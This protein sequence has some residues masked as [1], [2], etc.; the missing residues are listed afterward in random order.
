MRIAHIDLGRQWRGGQRQCLLLCESLVAAGHDIHLIVRPRSALALR[1]RERGL[2]VHL[3]RAWGELDPWSMVRF[4]R[5]L[6]RL[7]PDLI[8]AHEAHG[9]AFASAA[10][11]WWPE[12]SGGPVLVYHRRV[13][14]P[15][16]RSA[17]ARWKFKRVDRFIC[18]SRCIA[19]VLAASG[20][21]RDRISVVHS[22]T[23]GVDVP[24]GE[25]D[26][27]RGELG[28]AEEDLLLGTV[29]GLIPHKGHAVAID[30]LAE[31]RASD[32]GRR[33]HLMLVG[34][35]PLHTALQRQTR[36]LGVAPRV[37]L[38]GERGDLPRL[39]AAMDLFVHPSLSEGLGSSILDAFSA[40]VPVIA[41]NVGG[42]PEAVIDGRTGVLVPPGDSRALADA[43]AAAAEKPQQAAAY[44]RS[45]QALYGREFTARVMAR[46][47]LAV[48]QELMGT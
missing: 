5:R 19:D 35:G 34:S 38:L 39:Y 2:R 3:L 44:A 41:S 31:L 20:I 46:K 12:S 33:L 32:V 45:A 1:A 48:Y 26:A 27:L 37:H 28:L 15:I 23:R 42:I 36:A 16:G 40:G 10:R 7:R 29:G 11:A 24:A 43:I 25:R 9:L 22:G 30:A 4:A 21:E 6:R 8:A 13:D 17:W 14:V 47:T 18:V